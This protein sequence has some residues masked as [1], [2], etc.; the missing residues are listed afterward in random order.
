MDMRG[1]EQR[2]ADGGGS[3]DR[4]GPAGAAL[5]HANTPSCVSNLL[6]A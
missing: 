6:T 1:S 4:P 2:A 5:T 3:G